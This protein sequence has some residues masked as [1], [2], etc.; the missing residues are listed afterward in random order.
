MTR[1]LL[2]LFALIVFV[3]TASFIP[4]R[5]ECRGNGPMTLTAHKQVEPTPY[6]R[7]I[8]STV[9]N[10]VFDLPLSHP[11]PKTNF[12]KYF[13]FI[14]AIYT[15]TLSFKKMVRLLKQLLST[16][17][18]KIFGK[19]CSKLTSTPGYYVYLFRLS[20]F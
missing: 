18:I 15:V 8:I 2:S 14:T 17:N 5:T 12:F 9:M 11:K 20:P 3:N 19:F 13:L 4:A 6:G 7:T 1:Q 16:Y 10:S